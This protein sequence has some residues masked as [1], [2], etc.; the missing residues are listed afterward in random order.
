MEVYQSILA[1]GKINFI[2]GDVASSM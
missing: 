2:D 1:G